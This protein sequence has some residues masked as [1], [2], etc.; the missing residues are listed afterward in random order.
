MATNKTPEQWAEIIKTV[1]STWKMANT[2]AKA[3]A[4]RYSDRWQFIDFLGPAGHESAGIVDIVAIRKSGKKPT[5]EGLKSLD[6]FDIVLI[7]VKGGS[8][9][10]PSNEDVERLKKVKSHYHAQ[11]IVLFEW[12][13][14]KSLTRFSVLADG[15]A[16]TE[17]TSAQIFGKPDKSKKSTTTAASTTLLNTEPNAATKAWITRRAKNQASSN[18]SFVE[19]T[20]ESKNDFLNW[21]RTFRSEAQN[22]NYQVFRA[23]L[24]RLE[25]PDEPALLLEGTVL[26]VRSCVA[27]LMMDG[28]PVGNF[29]THQRYDPAAVTDAPY[30]V[31]FDVCSRAYARLT[32]PKSF[33]QL[34]FADLYDT[35]WEQY[36]MVGYHQFWISRAD[37]QD[38]TLDEISEFE[39]AVTKDLRFDYAEEEVGFWFDTSLIDGVLYGYLYDVVQD[40]E[41]IEDEILP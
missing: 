41:D 4:K 12:N 13:K 34:D 37:K 30:L 36:G 3:L 5:I 25:L 7:Q 32:M 17:K 11:E 40:D 21:E 22:D 8:A 1:H 39:N 33:G 28:R 14:N 6:L 27:F 20:S 10:M 35:P 23:H 38:L 24:E 31:T 26:F 2:L 19:P 16:W 15:D 9:G 18:D 29:L